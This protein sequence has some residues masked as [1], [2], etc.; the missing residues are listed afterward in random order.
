MYEVLIVVAAFVLAYSLVSGRLAKTIVSGPMVYTAFG[1]MV[2]TAVP[3]MFGLEPIGSEIK[4]ETLSAMAE[5]TLAF[6]LFTGAGGANFSQLRKNK[7]LPVRLL[8]IGLPLTI[9]VGY[10]VGTALFPDLSL[11]E[12]AILATIL[13]P[14]DAALGQAVV[15]N[16]VVPDDIREGLNAE[17]GL[18]DGVC[19]PF[20]LLFLGLATGTLDKSGTAGAAIGLVAQEIGIGAVSGALVTLVGCFFIGRAA[21]KGWIA[22]VWAPAPL[23]ALSL[24]AF[25]TAQ[26]A[27]GSGFIACFV[28]GL[29]FNVIIGDKRGDILEPASTFGELFQLLTWVLFGAFAVAP[30]IQAASGPVVLYALLSLTLARMIPVALCV[31]GLGCRTDT[32]LFMGWFG[33]RGLATIVFIVMVLDTDLPGREL[34]QTVGAWTILLSVVL[35]GITANPLAARYGARVKARS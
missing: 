35:H 30:S 8:L 25:G 6:V 9:A 23:V 3:S 31:V 22:A 19:V 28:G 1:F 18:N 5:F 29:V 26:L 12:V 2:S 21:T 16:P 33:P 15:T 24:L 34:I 20:L 27:G 10:V 13:A 14:T 4:R 17:S 7:A 32:K 11:F